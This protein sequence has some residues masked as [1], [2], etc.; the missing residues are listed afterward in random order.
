MEDLSLILNE[1]IQKNENSPK[2]MEF[3]AKEIG[4]SNAQLSRI[5]SKKSP[6]SENVINKIYEYFVRTDKKYA[7]ELKER[8]NKIR[9]EE[10]VFVYDS[11]VILTGNT[12]IDNYARLLEKLSQQNSLLIV[13]YRDFPVSLGRFPHIIELSV[14]AIRN[15]LCIGLFQPFGSREALYKRHNLFGEKSSKLT[16]PNKFK[17]ADKIVNSYDYLIRLAGEVNNLYQ[18]LKNKLTHDAKGQVVL[19]EA[20]YQNEKKVMGALPSIVAS[21]INS[22]LYYASFLDSTG[23]QTKIYEWISTINDEFLFIERSNTT[24]NFNAV[25]MQFNPMITYWEQKKRLPETEKEINEA[26]K[27][28]SLKTLFGVDEPVK[29]KLCSL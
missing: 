9:E 27:E 22:K 8:L 7:L 2:T 17:N 11:K 4:I 16:E 26:N 29:W 20:E 5:K 12:A 6:L 14:E 23:Y 21:G 25:K 15:G 3:F 18:S 19:Y 1:I 13:E 10:K 28:F 24:L